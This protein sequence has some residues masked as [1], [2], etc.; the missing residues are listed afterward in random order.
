VPITQTILNF[1]LPTFR[2]KK[3]AYTGADR[4]RAGLVEKADGGILFLDEVHRLP[5]EGQEMLF[6]LMDKGIYRRLG[7]SE[8]QHKANVLII[9]ATT[10]SIESV[11][12]RT[13]F[14]ANSDGNKIAQLGRKDAGGKV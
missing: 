12:L 13:F 9:C 6:Y 3:G 8:S 11:L 5:P 10:E 4:D 7:E 2:G 14:E 1:W